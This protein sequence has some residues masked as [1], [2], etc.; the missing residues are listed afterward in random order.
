[1]TSP[2]TALPPEG[3]RIA[4]VGKGGSGKS[5]VIGHLLA[6]WNEDGIPAAA[7]DAD[8]PGDEENGSLVEWADLADLGAPVYPAPSRAGIRERAKQVTPAG[9]VLAVDTGA[10]VRKAGGT[11]FA[12]LSAVDLAV[13]TMAPTR[14][15]LDRAGSILAA[16]EHLESVGAHCPALRI[17]LTMTNP[18]AAA[19]DEQE[20]ALTDAGYQVLRT[21]VPRSDSRDGYGQAF[22]RPPRLVSGSPMDQLAAELVAAAA[23]VVR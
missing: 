5:T 18:S 3:V 12:V 8:E 19:A 16:L 15:E 22:G 21:R 23:E 17:L 20:A 4:F 13:L 7:L 9:G 2:D 6:H 10:W 14:M 1:M 11:H